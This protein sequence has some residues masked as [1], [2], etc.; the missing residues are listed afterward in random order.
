M[1]RETPFDLLGLEPRFDVDQKA[2]QSAYL[3]AAAQCHPDRF[4][5]P[6]QREQAELQT[7]RLNEAKA[8]LADDEARA[9]LLLDLLGGPGP[10]EERSLPS[11]FLME[12]LDVREE[13][14]QAFA[15]GDSAERTR[16]EEWANA[17]RD[18]HI[19]TIAALFADIERDGRDEDR[20]RAVR[21]EL[22]RWRYIERMI[23]QLDPDHH[24]SGDS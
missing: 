7:A 6:E 3:R 14:E 12:M 1:S 9:N 21:L 8:V 24:P 5:T 23:E 16:L 2:V 4:N 11:E 17:R 20:L 18:E 19:A 13:M 10:S 15:S 22:N